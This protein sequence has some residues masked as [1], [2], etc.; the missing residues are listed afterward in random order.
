LGTNITFTLEGFKNG[1]KHKYTANRI[2]SLLEREGKINK[3]TEAA[4]RQASR[5]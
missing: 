3:E 5:P 4:K 2:Y 1:N